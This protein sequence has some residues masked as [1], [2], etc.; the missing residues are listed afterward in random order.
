MVAR[1]FP[2]YPEELMRNGKHPIHSRPGHLI[3]RLQ[4]IA[5]AIFMTETR[6]FNITPVQYSA[7]LAVE[8]HP[9]IDQ[10]TLV[11]V[12]ALDRS[13][14]GNVVG[15][16][17]SKKWIRRIAGSADR[18]SKCLTITAEGRKVLRA[19]DAAVESTQKLILAPLKPP[20]RA[21]FVDMLERLVNLNNSRSRVP[22]RAPTEDKQS[23][24][25]RSER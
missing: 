23:N 2:R 15:R 6:D 5:V 3:R 25:A 14:I 22:L 13:T 21:A 12:I 9:G 17:E 18:R 19:I 7:L 10:T 8:M 4:Q 20:E 1:R 11:N 24:Q 16:L